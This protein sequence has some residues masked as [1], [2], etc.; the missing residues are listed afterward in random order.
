MTGILYIKL[1]AY[2]RKCSIWGEHVQKTDS[3][4]LSTLHKHSSPWVEDLCCR[5][6][7]THTHVCVCMCVR[8]HT[9]KH[10]ATG[11]HTVDVPLR[12]GY[13]LYD[14]SEVWYMLNQ[15]MGGAW[16][17]ILQVGVAAAVYGRNPT[18]SFCCVGGEW[19]SLWVQVWTNVGGLEKAKPPSTEADATL[20][21]WVPGD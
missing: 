5:C 16:Y 15:P 11:T 8:T 19:G 17:N 20:E 4:A 14:I 3:M 6:M 7:H 1:R 21:A 13:Y 10:R 12:Q 9:L 18:A 2:D